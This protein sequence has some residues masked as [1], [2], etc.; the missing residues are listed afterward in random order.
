VQTATAHFGAMEILPD[1][2]SWLAE[3][4]PELVGARSG[5]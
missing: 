4:E 5:L 3:E 2:L 1:I